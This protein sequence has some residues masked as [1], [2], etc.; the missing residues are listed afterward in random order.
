MQ[1]CVFYI[2]IKQ[3]PFLAKGL[4]V[5]VH[6]ADLVFCF[7]GAFCAKLG[8]F[9]AKPKLFYTGKEAAERFTLQFDSCF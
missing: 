8:T 4:C 6:I 3:R 1:E 9:L 7:G 5:S 2:S